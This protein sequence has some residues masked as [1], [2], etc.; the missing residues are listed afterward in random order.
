[1][2]VDI[3]HNYRGNL[4]IVLVSPSGKESWLA[5]ERSD[6]G[7]DYDNW[8]F[9]TVHHWDES[10]LGNWQLRVRDVSS[11]QSG[12]L[13]HWSMI[14]HGTDADLDHDDDGLEDVNETEI[15]GT[16]PY[17][18]DTDD[19]NGNEQSVILTGVPKPIVIRCTGLI[20][21]V[22]SSVFTADVK[23]LVIFFVSCL[24]YTFCSF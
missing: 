5:E 22:A 13:N 16:D 8:T 15:W 19:V 9:N 7:N 4:E 14:F 18:P 24:C 10:S 1:M 17:D 2:V 12:T 11:G 3:S 21:F 6:N 20:S 23:L